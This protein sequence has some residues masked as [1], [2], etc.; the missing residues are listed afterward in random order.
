MTTFTQRF[1]AWLWK[2]E[3]FLFC[4]ETHTIPTSIGIW[5][6][7]MISDH[8]WRDGYEAAL[9]E[10]RGNRTV[11]LNCLERMTGAITEDFEPI[12]P[13]VLCCEPVFCDDWDAGYERAILLWRLGVDPAH[14]LKIGHLLTERSGIPIFDALIRYVIDGEL[15]IEPR[16]WKNK[17]GQFLQVRHGYQKALDM[18][19]HDYAEK[20]QQVRAAHLALVEHECVY[21]AKDTA[22]CI[23]REVTI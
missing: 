8:A 15:H 20:Y 16:I 1:C 3:I 19:Y 9:T 23:C 21:C 22:E 17:K 7:N 6:M 12:R 14:L 18:V 10:L 4:L 2:N 5:V 13:R 11:M